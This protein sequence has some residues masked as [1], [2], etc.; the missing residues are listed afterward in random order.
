MGIDET[1]SVDDIAQKALEDFYRNC[2]I[3][4]DDLE[5]RHRIISGLVPLPNWNY[6]EW[7]QPPLAMLEG[8]YLKETRIYH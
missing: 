8:Q 4:P 5:A 6:L 3:E 7:G 2:G 1:I